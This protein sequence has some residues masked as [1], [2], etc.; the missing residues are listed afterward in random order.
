MSAGLQQRSGGDVPRGPV[1]LRGRRSLERGPL[2]AWL[3]LP[4]LLGLAPGSVWAQRAAASAAADRAD[5]EGD[6]TASTDEQ[7]ESAPAAEPT[8]APPQA[9][10]E[11]APPA[12]AP[13]PQVVVE[14]FVGFGFGTRAFRRP[15]QMATGQQLPTAFFPAAEVGL[16]VSVW[17]ARRFSLELL[18]RYQSSIGLHVRQLPP[19]ALPN[20][21]SARA[22]RAELSAAPA[23]RLGDG[24]SAPSLA[25]PIGVGVRT[26]WPTVHEQPLVGYSLLGPQL[27]AEL[28]LPLA[29]VLRLRFGPELQWIVAV[30][31]ALR[32]EGVAAQGAAV[33]GEA[34]LQAR[35][36]P[37][38]RLELCYRESHA[39]ASSENAGPIFTD[40][41]RFATLR[42]SGA[43]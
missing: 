31:H 15:T 30:D 2:A 43:L 35:L 14:P 16:G 33:G 19:F 13:G 12:V 8:P 17:P 41:E 32:V 40:V 7:P 24:E 29:G 42:V 4:L 11:S 9:P 21:V 27:R 20:Q 1:L 18:L 26:F 3:L 10:A 28:V 6:A 25:F 22:E 34:R 5:E 38:F 39:F 36:G 23:F 37:V